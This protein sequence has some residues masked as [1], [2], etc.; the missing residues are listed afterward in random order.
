MIIAKETTMWDVAPNT[1]NHMYLLSDN[2]AKV[3]AYWNALDG[4]YHVLSAKG[5][6]FSAAR[7][8]FD[9][10]ERGVKDINEINTRSGVFPG[11]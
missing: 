2:K 1:P 7:R 9:I 5:S 8:R 6:N 10:L 4:S 11:K 3:Y